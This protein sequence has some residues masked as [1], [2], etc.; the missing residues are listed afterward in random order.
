MDWEKNRRHHVTPSWLPIETGFS[1]RCVAC[2]GRIPA[3]NPALYHPTTKRIAHIGCHGKRSH[4]GGKK[5]GR[6]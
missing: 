1:G 5:K 2:N 6:R 4:G 3:H